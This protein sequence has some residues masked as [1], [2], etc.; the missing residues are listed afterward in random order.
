MVTTEELN[1]PLIDPTIKGQILD[2]GVI[3]FSFAPQIVFGYGCLN[4]IGFLSLFLKAKNAFI[5]T[6]AEIEKLGFPD[7]VQRYL[8]KSGIQSSIFN[9]VEPNPKEETVIKA[10]EKFKSSGSDIVIA[11]GGGS[12]MDAAKVIRLIARQG[13]KPSDYDATKSTIM[14]VHEQL[15]HQISIP[16]TSGTGSEVSIV[17]MVTSEKNKVTILGYP[18][19]STIALIDPQ[20]TMSCPPKLTAYCGMD[21][22]THAIEAFV[23]L[24]VNPVADMFSLQAISIIYQNLKKSYS[25]GKD[26]IA[27]V[28]MALASAI[29]GMAFNQKSV[30]L[31]HA[32][33]H[34]L[35]SQCNLPHGLANAI[36]LPHVLKINK[37]VVAPKYA[38]M[39]TAF[40]ISPQNNSSDNEIADKFILEIEKLNKDIGIPP[41]LSECGV[42]VSDIEVM[43]QN[44]IKDIAALTNPLQP[45]TKEL[46]ESVYRTAL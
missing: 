39:A 3:S 25:D 13:G 42:K 10:A 6:D 36:M 46:V 19:I 29:A 43:A 4:R 38:I 12:V 17:A 45:I 34:Q 20:L 5:V 32:C 18:L 28:N 7:K 41:R 40:G 33:S 37:K 1:L 31:V 26:V 21:A 35:S 11:I 16:T 30:G 2:T 24:R 44:A 15:P 27:R 9:E 22:L 23:S 14:A 8:E